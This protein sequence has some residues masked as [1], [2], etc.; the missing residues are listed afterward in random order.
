M[1]ER[2]REDPCADSR[3]RGGTALLG[4][5]VTADGGRVD[6]EPA[7]A[8]YGTRG[9]FPTG[10]GATRVARSEELGG[11][12]RNLAD[13]ELIASSRVTAATKSSPPLLGDTGSTRGETKDEI[14][15]RIR[16]RGGGRKRQMGWQDQRRVLPSLPA[17]AA[18]ICPFKA[19][20]NLLEEGVGVCL[21]CGLVCPAIHASVG[22][23]QPV[24]FPPPVV[25]QGSAATGATAT[26]THQRGRP[27]GGARGGWLESPSVQSFEA[28]RSATFP[29]KPIQPIQPIHS[30]AHPGFANT[31]SKPRSLGGDGATW[32]RSRGDSSP[33][34]SPEA[35]LFLF[36]LFLLLSVG[37][38]GGRGW[39][40]GRGIVLPLISFLFYCV[41]R[42]RFW[43]PEAGG[44]WHTRY[45]SPPLAGGHRL[46][47]EGGVCR[48]RSQGRIIADCLS[49]L[50]RCSLNFF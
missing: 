29:P 38:G 26:A 50:F 13:T 48:R 40:A 25:L 1:S 36:P 45:P 10:E 16:R 33:P 31:G 18:A 35:P 23:T 7:A 47:G 42:R 9:K 15:H 24:A 30:L 4:P 32:R 22:L 28:G 39:L 20:L 49:L 17:R 34:V 6:L 8:Q 41:G 21:E 3:L 44:A 5:C 14:A 2:E 37:W 43:T 12:S 19:D 27:G 11:S 46:A